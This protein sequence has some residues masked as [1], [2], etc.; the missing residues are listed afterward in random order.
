MG[1]EYYIATKAHEAIWPRGVVLFW[2]PNGSGYSTCLERAGRYS[3]EDAKKIT[4]HHGIDF[5]IPCEVVEQHAIRVVDIDL[6]RKLIPL[7]GSDGP[8]TER[9]Q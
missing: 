8:D 7:G 1:Q 2:A 3:E 6:L 5:M 9:D 4:H